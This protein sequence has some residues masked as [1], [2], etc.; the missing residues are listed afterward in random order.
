MNILD[1][2]SIHACTSCQV[3]AAVCPKQAISIN[4]NQE[5]FYR[6]SIDFDK[7]VDCGICKSVCYKFAEVPSYDDVDNLV[8]YAASAK[9]DKT[10]A[11]TTSGGIGDILCEQLIADGYLCIGVEYDINKNIAVNSIASTREESLSF[12]GSKYVQ[13]YTYEAFKEMVDHHL[14][15]KVAVFGTSC[16]IFALDR[17]LKKRHKRDNFIL[18]DIYC[19]GCP[20]INIWKKYVDYVNGKT[21][22]KQYDSVSFRSKVYGWGNYYVAQ[23]MKDGKKLFTSPKINDKF[24]T[25]FF[26]DVLLNDSCYDC[27]MRSTMDSTD[28]RIGDFWGK[29]YLKNS[30]GMSLV[31]INPS[32]EK[33]L[34]L[35]EQVKDKISCTQH[36]SE[37][38]I[39]Y[40][41]WG[42]S[43]PMETELR[44]KLSA[45]LND[46]SQT[47]EDTVRLYWSNRSLP[48][49][50]KQALKNVIL[51]MPRPV[52]AFFKG[53][54]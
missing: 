24:Y 31:T 3:C 47:I 4:L 51:A 52:V 49:K 8:N 32:S 48:A 45:S 39:P 6:P 28:I 25:L 37:D 18:I 42:K 30:R 12:R 11:H 2:D 34:N 17:Y 7:C 50:I 41:S 43:Y 38:C 35:F 26:S 1:K 40:Q 33:G 5:G 9:G 22:E 16:H 15:E 27:Q 21:G 44:S 29:K 53:I 23:M 10:I 14:N 46:P 20:S 13:S 54:V 19:H 36:P